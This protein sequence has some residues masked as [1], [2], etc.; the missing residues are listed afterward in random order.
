MRRVVAPGTKDVS[1]GWLRSFPRSRKARTGPS[2]PCE[3][4]GWGLRCSAGAS[5]GRQPLPGPGGRTSGRPSGGVAVSPVE[6]VLVLPLLIGIVLLGALF[7]WWSHTQ[8]EVDRAAQRAARYAAVPHIADRA[9]DFCHPKVLAVVNED[10]QTSP[11]GNVRLDV[12]DDAGPAGDVCSAPRGRVSVTISH[13]V[14][15]PFTPLVRLIMPAPGTITVTATGRA[16]VE[17]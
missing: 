6:V 17:S 1:R 14:E 5:N 8:A 7:G 13:T 2:C 15:N 4:A 10:L 3:L 11:V 16:P 9:Y 12:R